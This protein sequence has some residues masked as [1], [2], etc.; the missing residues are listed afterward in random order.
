MY[1]DNVSVNIN[2]SPGLSELVHYNIDINILSDIE[3][4]QDNSINQLNSNVIN[5]NIVNSSINDIIKYDYNYLTFNSLDELNAYKSPW[6]N[7]ICY[8]GN[9]V[10]KYDGTSW[11]LISI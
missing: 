1:I 9:V 4:I 2:L 5:F 7:M 11:N 10:Y 8:V 6:K 3:K